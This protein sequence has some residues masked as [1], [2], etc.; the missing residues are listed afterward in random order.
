[1]YLGQTVVMLRSIAMLKEKRDTSLDTRG[2]ALLL[3]VPLR[4]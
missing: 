3:S 1:M 4:I 2:D